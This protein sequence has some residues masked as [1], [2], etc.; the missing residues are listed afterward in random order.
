MLLPYSYDRQ[1]GFVDETGCWQIKPVYSYAQSFSE[2]LAIVRDKD[3]NWGA[4]D[5]RGKEIIPFVYRELEPFWG[6][7]AVGHR[8]GF[9]EC[10]IVS[11][12]GISV[13]IE[14]SEWLDHLSEFFVS[15][16]RRSIDG[17][18]IVDHKGE[19]VNSFVYDNVKQVEPYF[20]FIH[21]KRENAYRIEDFNG[22]ILRSFDVDDMW[23][24]TQGK[25]LACKDGAWGVI[26]VFGNTVV[27]MKFRCVTEIDYTM[28]R[29]VLV[30]LF[31]EESG[32]SHLYDIKTGNISTSTW[33]VDAM[34]RVPT[35]CGD[36]YW[37]L[38]NDMWSL[39]ND[40]F[41]TIM[42]NVGFSMVT[43]NGT[44]DLVRMQNENGF[45]YYALDK[46]GYRQLF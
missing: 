44:D 21:C 5:E 17:F 30:E 39:L 22:R 14:D 31:N 32:H 9:S 4:I 42:A 25:S 16:C 24:C 37:V 2:G 19:A 28:D 11:R 35:E 23:S 7:F 3:G 43:I 27:P 38:Q 12:N 1:W 36:V 40:K 26:D 15:V 33:I 41:E 45:R 20:G 18:T 10:E 13:T 8:F 29:Y 6:G 46:N 34:V